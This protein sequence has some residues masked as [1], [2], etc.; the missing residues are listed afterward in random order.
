ML[1]AHLNRGRT[2]MSYQKLD[3]W[4]SCH[5]LTLA[6]YQ[7]TREFRAR[8]P[9]LVRRLCYTAT[10]AGGRVA[11]G[12]GTRNRR[13][14]RTAAARASGYLTEFAYD[15]SLAR[16][17]EVLPEKLCT[18]LDALRGRAAFYTSQLL[19]SLLMPPNG[20]PAK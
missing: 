17:M 5:A 6:V 14:F 19:N 15:L 12:S 1:G 16:V 7:A 10:R 9:R 13:M 11:F 3:A 4:K 20:G 18:Q 8:D 2:M